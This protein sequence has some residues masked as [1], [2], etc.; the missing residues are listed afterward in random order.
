[1]A[2]TP[3]NAILSYEAVKKYLCFRWLCSVVLHQQHPLSSIFKNFSH[4]CWEYYAQIC[5]VIQQTRAFHV[6][7]GI[8]AQFANNIRKTEQ[9]LSKFT[10]SILGETVI[11]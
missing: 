4:S 7:V 9:E 8:S 5:E 11:S 6:S 2:V 10:S 3:K 1:M